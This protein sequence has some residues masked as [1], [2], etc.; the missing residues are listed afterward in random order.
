[1]LQPKKILVRGPNWLGDH[2][3]C[4]PFYEAVRERFSG[5]SLELL[6]PEALVG[7]AHNQIFDKVVPLPATWR[8]GVQALKQQARWLQT[9][10]YDLSVSLPA[11]F[12]AILPLYLAKV[13]HRIG[14]SQGGS[15]L[16]L[17]Q[18]LK[19]R[20][21]RRGT[22]KGEH[23][24]DLLALLEVPR[25]SPPLPAALVPR[26]SKHFVVGPGAALPLREWPYFPEFVQWLSTAYPA[27]R[28]TLVG[29]AGDRKW[30]SRFRR[31][32]L[33]S[34]VDDRIGLTTLNELETLCREATAVIANDSGLAH[35]AATLAEAPTLVLCGPGD[36]AY[37][38]PRGPAAE[39]SSLRA[40]TLACQPCESASC[41]N[42][43]AYQACLRE[44]TLEA[45]Q[46][47]FANLLFTTH[48]GIGKIT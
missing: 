7:L 12:S 15:G 24:L 18:A 3:L 36:P 10:A 8:R 41:R 13:P 23:Y 9:Q 31:L 29:A 11:S 30:S 33:P 48:S 22:H 35:L 46:R 21:R 45:V 26:E 32:G 2:V 47:D 14:F 20:G 17:S 4:F 5:A 27:Y 1:M 43:S 39:V 40:G 16:F 37:I 34:N 44:L 6:L 38:R 28:V 19:W 42:K 25:K